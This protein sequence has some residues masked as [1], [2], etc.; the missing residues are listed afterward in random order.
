MEY[1]D[2]FFPLPP[3]PTLPNSLKQI[4]RQQQVSYNRIKDQEDF[5]T[6]VQNKCEA[7]GLEVPKYDLQTFVKILGLPV[8]I[9]ETCTTGDCGPMAAIKQLKMLKDLTEKEKNILDFPIGERNNELRT[10]IKTK[11]TLASDPWI[12]DYKSMYTALDQ[13]ADPAPGG[14][15]WAS[16]GALWEEMGKPGVFVEECFWLSLAK[17]LERDVHIV[18]LTC[19]P[20]KPFQSFSGQRYDENR[21]QEKKEPMFIGYSAIGRHYVSLKPF[22][23]A[24]H[25]M[26]NIV[27]AYQAIQQRRA[28]QGAGGVEAA[29]DE[30]VPQVEAVAAVEG[31]DAPGEGEGVEAGGGEA[32]VSRSQSQEESAEDER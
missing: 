24:E 5:F 30:V 20:F 16:Y 25:S 15:K 14:R 27:R 13:I 23:F 32:G 10:F 31:Y 1:P 18:S 22:I 8:D 7:E 2:N 12:V 28:V 11:M 17:V 21:L 4:I 26:V 3:N 29:E 19:S 9:Q 6:S